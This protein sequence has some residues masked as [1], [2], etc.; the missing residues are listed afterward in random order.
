MDITPVELAERVEEWGKLLAPLGV[1]HW[2]IGSV[3]LLEDDGTGWVARA[4]TSLQYDRCWFEFKRDF[5]EAATEDDLDQ[6]ILHEWMHVAMR[7]MDARIEQAEDWMPAATYNL[8]KDA[9]THDMEG[10]VDRLATVL[11]QFYTGRDPRFSPALDKSDTL[12]AVD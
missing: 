9:V 4:K 3:A 8:W 10:V 7:N 2:H 12:E 1:A 6:I 11:L 5:V